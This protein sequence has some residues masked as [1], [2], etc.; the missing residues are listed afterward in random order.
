MLRRP[1]LPPPRPLIPPGRPPMDTRPAPKSASVPEAEAEE[2]ALAPL[3]APVGWRDLL[4]VAVAVAGWAAFAFDQAH[5]AG[6]AS[7]RR[8][9]AYTEDMLD[10]FAESQANE[11]Y[12]ALSAALKPWWDAIR[13][14]QGRIL[15][16]ASEEEKSRLIAER[17]ASLVA[18]VR[19]NRLDGQIAALLG[20]FER[21]NRCLQTELCDADILRRSIEIDVKL[22]YRTFRP[23]ILAVREA[24]PRADQF[25][26]DLEAL[27]LRFLG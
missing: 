22:I 2:R 4:L 25:G 24:D 19:A 13:P 21:F 10:N 14:L 8:R 16:A 7:E 27:Y 6:V 17:D 9:I 18:F 3:G 23:W 26:R 11:A 5:D 15:A 1:V 12:R 20:Y